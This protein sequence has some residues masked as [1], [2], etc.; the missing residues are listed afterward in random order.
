MPTTQSAFQH[1]VYRD[2]ALIALAAFGIGLLFSLSIA[3]AIVLA[4]PGGDT[5]PQA[6]PISQASGP[7]KTHYALLDASVAKAQ[8][9]S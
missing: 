4:S 3:T 5:S 2:F 7:Y 6:A 1:H 9:P 8:N